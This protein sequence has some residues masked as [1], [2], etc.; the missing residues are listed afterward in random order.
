MILFALPIAASSA[1]QQLFNSADVAVAGQFAGDN[2]LAA[3]GANSAIINLLVNLFVGLSVGANAVIASYLGREDREGTSR[4]VHTSIVI[5]FVSGI[6]LLIIGQLFARPILELVSTPAE[7]IDAAESYFRIYFCGMPFIMLYNFSAAI[8]RSKGDTTRPLIVLA[9][10]GVINII[11]NLVFVIVLHIGVSGVA[12]ATVISNVISSITL[13]IF[14]TR[15]TGPLKVEFRK[16]KI[17]KTAL[18]KI[19]QI[20]I[21]AGMQG[22][23]FSISNVLIQSALNALG[24]QYISASTAAMN[25]EY[26]TYFVISSFSQTTVTFIGQNFGAGNFARCKKVTKGAIIMGAASTMTVCALFLVFS[27]IGLRLF[28]S[29]AQVIEIATE[30]LWLIL[31][32]EIMNLVIDVLSGTMRGF[33]R[34]TAPALVCVGG[35]CGIRILYLYTVYQSIASFGA[36]MAVYPISWAFTVAALIII[37]VRA[38]KVIYSKKPLA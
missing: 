7:I 14:L 18:K 11:L 26:F 13:F 10:A 34:S 4:A 1:L 6:F 15:E 9:I 28:T 12:L 32:F 35:I 3:V 33:G 24:P 31:P 17:D 22:V 5:S 29:D 27:Q 36:L 20:G 8:L 19:S 38:T 23:V 2:A 25:F 30:R 37:Y 21:P 16:L